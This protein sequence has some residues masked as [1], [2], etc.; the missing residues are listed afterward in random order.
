MWWD[1]HSH[2]AFYSDNQLE[3]IF[4]QGRL[5]GLTTWVQGGYNPQDW[6]RQEGLKQRFPQQIRTAYGLHPWAL[7]EMDEDTRN[8]A[9]DELQKMAP[10]AH[11]IGETGLDAYRSTDADL[12]AIEEEF[13]VRHLELA[14]EHKKPVVLH[15]VRAHSQSLKLL[16]QHL[17]GNRG[18]VHAFS[19]SPD[20][21]HQYVQRGFLISIGPGL[22]KKATDNLNRRWN[23][24]TPN[25]WWW[26][27]TLPSPQT[28]PSPRW[29]WF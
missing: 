29:I 3:Q 22:L 4:A 17:N 27:L 28:I 7:A 1:A 14:A 13:L 10:A 21:A 25:I 12:L 15:V 18:I 19:S 16:D 23:K 2:M 26:S 11:L 8:Q 20:V 24:S 5:M 6:R 9:W